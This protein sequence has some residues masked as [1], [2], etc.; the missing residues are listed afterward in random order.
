MYILPRPEAVVV[1]VVR[2]VEEVGVVATRVEVEATTA[3]DTEVG[4]CGC[5]VSGG[6]AMAFTNVN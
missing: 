5:V 2:T 4:G 1:N 3:A 6:V